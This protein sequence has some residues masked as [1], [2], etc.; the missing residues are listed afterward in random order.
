MT[1]TPIFK[2]AIVSASEHKIEMIT[3]GKN[4]V[5][6]NQDG[7]DMNKNIENKKPCK[8]DKDGG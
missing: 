6:S 1:S 7:K 2:K 8:L 5:E 4:L 3:G